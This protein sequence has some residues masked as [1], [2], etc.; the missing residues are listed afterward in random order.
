MLALQVL[1]PVATGAQANWRMNIVQQGP[2]AV[3]G[4][5]GFEITIWND[6]PSNIAQLFYVDSPSGAAAVA[7][8]SQ[9]SCV[10]SPDLTCRLGAL[11]ANQSATIIVAYGP[12]SGSSFSYQGA[13]NAN[14]STFKDI[15]KNSRG[16]S[17]LFPAGGPLATSICSG[18]NCAGGFLLEGGNV[19]NDTNLH[20]SR[21]KQSTQLIGI[22][23]LTGAF[24]Q[25][26]PDVLFNCGTACQQTFVGEWSRVVVGQGLPQDAPFRVVLTINGSFNNLDLG[27]VLATHVKDD[28]AVEVIGDIPAE[29][30]P[31][32]YTGSLPLPSPEGC[33][34]AS[35]VGGNLQVV[36]WTLS[37]GGY[38]S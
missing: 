9:G 18:R 13:A 38:R 3:G 21:N 19:A 32:G 37:N 28:G 8:P 20:P 10:R 36:I 4:Y 12:L 35:R 31:A 34:A 33:L 16:D 23:T 26:G 25:D 1:A 17:L 27:M 14:G 22:G 7:N 15:G 2:V 5:V 6:G 30:C 29:R 11:N 24:V